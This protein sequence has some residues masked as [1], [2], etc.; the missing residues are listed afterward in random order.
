MV[1]GFTTYTDPAVYQ[2]EVIVPTGLNIPAQPF[3][4]TLIGTGS[5]NKRVSNEA[6]LRGYISDESIAPAGSSPHTA[7][8]DARGNRKVAHTTVRRTLNGITT[9]LASQYVSFEPALITGTATGTFDL[10]ATNAFSLEMDGKTPVQLQ[11]FDTVVATA[12]NYAFTQVST[13]TTLTRA[14]ETFITKG[15]RPGMTVVI[16]LAEDTANNGTFTILTVTETAISYTNASGVANAD[17]DTAVATINGVTSVGALIT[18]MQAFGGTLA[19]A[20]TRAEVAGAINAGLAASSIYGSDYSAV[21][22][23]ATTG[24]RITS[25]LDPG[26]S[27]ADVRVFAAI[28]TNACSVLFGSASLDA[29]TE[30]TI[31]NVVWNASATWTIDYV[32]F[33]SE[34]DALT[35][36]D[37]QAVVMVGSQPGVGRFI[38]ARDFTLVAVDPDNPPDVDLPALDWTTPTAAAVS[39][40]PA[41]TTPDL[42][43][44]DT[45]ILALDGRAEETIVIFGHS[46]PLP[47]GYT[48]DA[49]PSSTTL[50][51]NV[52][53]INAILAA[54]ATYGPRYRSV[55]TTNGTTITLTSP[56]VGE[57]SSIRIKAPASESAVTTL[58]GLT[59]TQLGSNGKSYTGVGKRPTIGS[60]YY[61]S[62]DYTRPDSDYNVP[63]RHFSKDS[64]ISQVGAVS[65]ATAGYNPLAVASEIA[66]RNGA[67]FIYTIQV[68]DSSAEG[69]PTR[70]EVLDALDAA[71]TIAGA[72]EI[73]VL[74]EPGTRLDVMTDIIDHL[75][76]QNGPFEKHYRRAFLGAASGTE[77]GDNGDEG[78]MVDLC[79]STLQVVASS[80]A[81]GRMFFIAPPQLDGVTR[82]LLLEDGSSVRVSLDGTYLAVAVAARRT[83]L[84]G[85]AETLTRRRIVGFNT[86]D[87]TAPWSTAERRLLAGNGALVITYDAGQF[88]MLDAMSTEGGGGGLDSFKVDSS[89]YQ[90]DVVVTKV[91]QAL[92]ANIVGI[93]PFDLSNFVLDI[94]LIIQGVVAGEISA[95][96]IGPFRDDDG[97]TR[98]IDLRRDIRVVQSTTSLTQFNFQ[99]W[100]NLR[101]PALRLLGEYSVDNPWFA[102]TSQT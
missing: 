46:A 88:K 87:I 11:L 39:F 90:K 86:D 36:D 20:A 3:A 72:T 95:R 81:R 38:E 65:A 21:A 71:K 24:I 56:N 73:C 99:Y 74:G 62:Y 76:D 45:I 63:V 42:S 101:Y 27:P 14:T 37:V 43:T 23:D 57:S 19:A 68:D 12:T 13:T 91:D 35:N 70:Q 18:V 50:A 67:P 2:Q 31:A 26:N 28:A 52:A 59:T 58:T 49:S 41:D 77:I 6:V 102:L 53:N 44:D 15:V 66:F 4:V 47:L 82:D 64:A 89:S 22:T 54:S 25:P 7:T 17:D 78:S 48:E 55:A 93:V 75:E 100:F 94:K 30:V 8:L 97:A 32:A 69:N 40:S 10:S 61:V 92:D 83:S 96:S 80:P 34:G 1:F 33:E 60:V 84:P 9:A 5:R 98:A 51:N 79:V 29:V 16:T 85:P